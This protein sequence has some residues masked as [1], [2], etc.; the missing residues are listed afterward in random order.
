MIVLDRF[1]QSKA[2]L[3]R[4]QISLLLGMCD[5]ITTEHFQ[6][7]VAGIAS[8]WAWGFP[9]LSPFSILVFFSK[10]RENQTLI[11]KPVEV[12]R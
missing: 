8:K 7:A 11:V 1:L 5:G 6:T 9:A 3:S 2:G 12:F 4:L 10:R